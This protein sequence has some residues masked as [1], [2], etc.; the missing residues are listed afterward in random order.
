MMFVV[1]RIWPADAGA[2]PADGNL[3]IQSTS[4]TAD[5]AMSLAEAAVTRTQPPRKRKAMDLTYCEYNLSTMKDSKGGFLYEE[6]PA[7]AAPAAA[8]PK[9]AA[10]KRKERE[11]G[12]MVDPSMR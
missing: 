10:G 3:E 5:A 11:S 1:A 8:A 4:K 12:R 6:E 7:E 9:P 2:P